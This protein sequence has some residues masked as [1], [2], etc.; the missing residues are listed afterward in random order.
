MQE[1]CNW[2]FGGGGGDHNKEVAEDLI[3]TGLTVVLNYLH[4]AHCTN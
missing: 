1:E 2:D 3:V 4:Y